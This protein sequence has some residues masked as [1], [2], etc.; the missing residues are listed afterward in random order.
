MF[1]APCEIASPVK[2]E[3]AVWPEQLMLLGRLTG[4]HDAAETIQCVIEMT[5]AMAG[6]CSAE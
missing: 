5:L 2:I 6:E 3:V 1:T 4:S